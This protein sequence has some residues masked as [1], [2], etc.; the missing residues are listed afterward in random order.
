MACGGLPE[1]TRWRDG[2][3]W[4][5]GLGDKGCS[6]LFFSFFFFFDLHLLS[7]AVA[8]WGGNGRVEGV[9]AAFLPMH[10]DHVC[11]LAG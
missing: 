5:C 7:S 9:A 11:R 3:V 6:S 10:M 8:G 2:V 4:M 1:G